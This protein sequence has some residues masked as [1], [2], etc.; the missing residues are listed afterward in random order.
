[1]KL[2]GLP[3]PFAVEKAIS[4][5][6][7]CDIVDI[8]DITLCKVGVDAK[9]LAEKVQRVQGLGLGLGDGG[10]VWIARQLAETHKVSPSVLQADALRRRVGR[11][12]VEH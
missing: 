6:E 4:G 10:N 1:M 12:V 3:F 7:E 9:L 2:Q 11:R 8:L 5:V